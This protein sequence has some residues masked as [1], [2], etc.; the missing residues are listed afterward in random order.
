MGVDGL[1]HDLTI[2]TA[3]TE[4]EV[5][6]QLEA[7]LEIEVEEEEEVEEGGDGTQRA[8]GALEFLT[9]DAET[10]GTILIDSRNGFN[11]LS[12]FSIMWTVGHH[13]TAGARFAFNCYRHLAQLLL[14]QLGE[15]PVTIL[16]REGVTQ[17]DPLS[18]VLY[19]ITLVFLAEELKTA[20]PGILSPFYADDAAF[21]G[22][23]RQSAQLLKLLMQRGLDQRY[24]PVPAKSLLISD[25]MGQ[26]AAA[27]WEF[28]VEGLTL[29]FVSGSR[30]LG[31][32]LG[33][34]DQLEAWVKRQTE[35][36]AH[37][38]RVL[39]QIYRR[40]PQS[41]YDGLGILLQLEWQY[42]QRTVP[43]FGTLMGPIEEDL[44]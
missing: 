8:L 36:W 9:Q 14:R 44:R 10:N 6:E 28:A 16:S 41:A 4:E 5:A 38:I 26:E 7:A 1:L 23:A 33:L 27:K 34:R 19:S 37:I 22:L 12:R 43:G 21:D 13:W 18:M 30:Y 17:G 24:S 20:D 40:H 15:L 31:A 2:E 39:G 3:G 35:A 25:K 29:N 32:Y 42:L 11:K